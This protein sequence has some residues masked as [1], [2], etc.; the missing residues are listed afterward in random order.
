MIVFNRIG[1]AALAALASLVCI[2]SLAAETPAR[3]ETAK[4]GQRTFEAYDKNKD[5]KITADEAR[6]DQALSKLFSGL[7]GDKDGGI[8]R[9]EFAAYDPAGAA[10]NL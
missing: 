8:S 6:E 4:P 7:D 1:T 5:G 3:N 9:A 10:K 2:S